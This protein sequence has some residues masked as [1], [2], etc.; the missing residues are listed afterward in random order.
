MKPTFVLQF[1]SN[2]LAMVNENLDFETLIGPY[3]GKLKAYALNFTHDEENAADLMQDTLLKAYT[4]FG[5]FRPETN[6]RAWLFTIM[7]NTF[8]NDY[9]RKARVTKVVT[10]EEELSSAQL[11][12]S[13]CRNQGELKFVNGDIEK[14]LK[15]LPEHLFVPFMRYFEG[16][17]YHEI[18]VELQLPIGTVKTRI[19]YARISLKKFLKVYGESKGEIC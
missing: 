4:Y 6:F 10:V 7:K 18:A 16:F 14:A 11:L 13:C 17:K 15:S 9:R 2:T 3:Q 8:I 1:K 12:I 5:K 19:H